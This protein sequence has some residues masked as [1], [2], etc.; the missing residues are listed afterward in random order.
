MK[1]NLR[2]I[3]II[4]VYRNIYIPTI[5]EGDLWLPPGW[6]SGFLW[7]V[8]ISALLWVTCDF[9]VVDGKLRWWHD[10]IR[11]WWWRWSQRS[12]RE[13]VNVRSGV[14]LFRFCFYNEPLID[15][16]FYLS[17]LTYPLPTFINK[18]FCFSQK[19]EKK[20]TICHL[21]SQTELVFLFSAEMTEGISGGP[22]REQWMSQSVGHHW[23]LH[24]YSY[25]PCNSDAKVFLC[26]IFQI[27]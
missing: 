22:K 13:A 11:C 10:V 15:F 24:W 9:S 5:N 20:S 16:S 8:S 1:E 7:S 4:Y 21:F 6:C 18:T 19:K 17:Q 27:G 26:S 25:T 14:F 2:L 12:F 23:P 3:S